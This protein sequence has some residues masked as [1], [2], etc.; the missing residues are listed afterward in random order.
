M[1]RA[2]LAPPLLGLHEASVQPPATRMWVK[3]R[4]PP[5]LCARVLLPLN[6][7]IAMMY[8]L[9][10]PLVVPFLDVPFKNVT[11]TDGEHEG[12]RN[13]PCLGEGQDSGTTAVFPSACAFDPNTCCTSLSASQGTGEQESYFGTIGGKGKAFFA[14]V[15]VP[16]ML[17]GKKKKLAVLCGRFYFKTRSNSL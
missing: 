9:T 8:S 15:H 10:Q 2:V 3:T 17:T 1:A 7:C 4:K 12:D 13:L 11:V 5:L 16:K 14:L 6:L